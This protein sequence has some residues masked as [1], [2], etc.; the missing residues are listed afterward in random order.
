MA[1]K[2][3]KILIPAV[4]GQGGGVLTEWIY[5]A[6]LLESFNVQSISLPGLAQ[7]TGSTIYYIEACKN[8]EN[9]IVFSQYPVPG[10]IDIILSQE[11]LELGRILELG[12]GS[13]NTFVISST[14]RVYSTIEK[15]PIGSGVYTDDNLKSIAEKY[16]SKFI[17][18]NALSLAKK[19]GMN[20]LSVNAILLGLLSASGS[21]PISKKSFRDSISNFGIAVE[22]N[23]TAFD[24]GFDYLKKNFD[25]KTEDEETDNSSFTSYDLKNRDKKQIEK[26]L[27]K[28]EN[29]FPE[30]L[31]FLLEEA[32]IRLTDYQSIN[33]AK[34]YLNIIED[35][36]ELEKTSPDSENRL[37]EIVIK[38]L[39]LMMSYEDGIRV[40][41]LK[42]R[43]SRF[44]RI[45]EEMSIK[46]DQIYNVKDYLKPDSEEVYGL[47]PNIVVVPFLNFLGTDFFKKIWN[48]KTPLT[49]GQT[50]V[51]TSFL[52]YL[53]LWVISKLKFIRPYSYRYKKEFLVINKYIDSIQNYAK[54]DYELACIVAKSGSII[55]GYGKV[56][57]RT[58]NVFDRFLENVVSKSFNLE[59][60]KNNGFK[61][62]KEASNK[63]LEF[64][65]K[66]EKGIVKAEE[67]TSILDQ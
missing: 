6:F 34:K 9:K 38:N 19:N 53:R 13:D 12:Y 17:G 31:Y 54:S 65:S 66:D 40:S 15:L 63:A 30:Y 47:F 50:P 24:L 52:G 35:I 18:V 7:R 8:S 10:H 46:D 3:I 58:M 37:T 44:N 64:I 26:L 25:L 48:R 21:I 57:R 11:F 33:Y 16:S 67:L 45:K 41:E 5:Q 56:R 62:T 29:I 32:L 39:A 42:V 61:K 20:D 59:L 23:L 1:Q 43:S 27:G 51:T 36:Y 14:H 28:V 60:D 55:K 2:L 49:F 4:G 22:N